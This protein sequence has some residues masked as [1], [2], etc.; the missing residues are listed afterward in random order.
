MAWVAGASARSA[1]DLNIILIGFGIDRIVLERVIEQTLHH[2]N[3]NVC[4]IPSTNQTAKSKTV[5]IV[6]RSK[7]DYLD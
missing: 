7:V 1:S 6:K 4:G 3:R 5:T 2:D